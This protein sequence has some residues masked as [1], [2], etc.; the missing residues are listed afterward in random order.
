MLAVPGTYT[1]GNVISFSV[2]PRYRLAGYFA[3][4]GQYSFITTGADSY[5]IPVLP[6]GVLTPTP[7]FGIASWTAQQ[8]GGGFTYSSIVRSN[9]GPGAIPFEVSYSHLETITGSGG[10]VNKTFRDQVELR[11]YWKP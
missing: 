7:P 11:I 4:T 1:P 2:V 3:L 9:R 5:S 8:V 6:P 10:P